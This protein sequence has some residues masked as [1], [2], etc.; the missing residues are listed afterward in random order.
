MNTFTRRDALRMFSVGTTGTLLGLPQIS[1]YLSVSQQ[2]SVYCSQ[3][4]KEAE[5][6]IND[7]VGNGIAVFEFTPADGWLVVTTDGIVQ[8]NNIPSACKVKLDELIQGGHQ[9]ISVSFPPQGSNSWVIITDK[10]YAASQVGK[11]ITDKLD[12]LKQKGVK[13]KQIAF[14][15]KTWK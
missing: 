9:I 4:P 6:A 13:I 10:T 7:L 3:I 12:E 15:P 2:S 8:S 5:A 11:D 1:K 14:R